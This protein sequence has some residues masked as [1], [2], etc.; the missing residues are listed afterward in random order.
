[1]KKE[2]RLGLALLAFVAIIILAGCAH[3]PPPTALD[4]PGFLKGVLH[5]FIM[6]FSFV[7]SIFTDVRVYAF[8]NTGFFYDFGFVLGGAFFWGALGSEF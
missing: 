1:M 7:G 8:P 3:Q 5:G 4:P 2:N 6:L